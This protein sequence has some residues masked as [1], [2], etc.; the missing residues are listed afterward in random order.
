MSTPH[1]SPVFAHLSRFA[2][3]TCLLA[4]A[5]QASSPA[6]WS[7]NDKEVAATCAKASGLKDAQPAGQPMVYDDRVG[8]TA[9]LIQGRY[10]QPHMKNRIGRELCLFDRE[11]R[12]AAVTE[13]DQMSLRA[14]A[15]VTTPAPAKK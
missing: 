2:I 1:L 3:C 6:A 8:I 9:L 4:G 5:A 10:P 15:P 13:A 11:T 12:E 14:T 7:E